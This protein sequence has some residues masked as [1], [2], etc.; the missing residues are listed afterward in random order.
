[1]VW[2]MIS[3][4]LIEDASTHT[5]QNSHGR[6][7]GYQGHELSFKMANSALLPAAVVSLSFNSK[8]DGAE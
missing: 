2:V 4:L 6:L 5:E 3:P 1:M 7:F 8:A